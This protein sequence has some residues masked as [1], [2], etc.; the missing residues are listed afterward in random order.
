MRFANILFPVDSSDRCRRAAPHVLE[1]VKQFQARLSL[2][3]VVEY[4]PLAYYGDGVYLPENLLDD[5]QE[6]ARGMVA[7]FAQVHFPGIELTT[8]V[9]QG[10][11][12]ICIGDFAKNENVDLI[13]MPTHGHGRFRQA[14]L[15]SVTGKVLHDAEC[16]VWTDA[17]TLEE[18]DTAHVHWRSIVCA[19]S[20]SPQDADLVRFSR[21]LGQACNAQVCLVHAVPAPER[22]YAGTLEGGDLEFTE[23]LKDSARGS[24]G[25]V[26]KDAGTD[27]KLCVNA[28]PVAA[29][30]ADAAR[31]YKADV[32]LIGRGSMSK[33]AGRLRT[34]EYSIIREAPCPVLSI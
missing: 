30:V 17:H 32:V 6:S 10:D 18:D 24:I 29:V 12:G 19:L 8:R 34:H 9:D 1:A 16:P 28:G 11:P 26:Q 2:L 21:G 5:L 15:G 27:F 13:M 20:T 7:D 33:F 31:R 22:G 25:A 3:H 23:F 14:L 4:P